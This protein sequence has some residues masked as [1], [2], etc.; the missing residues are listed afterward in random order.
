LFNLGAGNYTVT[1]VDSFG[2]VLNDVTIISQP[3]SLF[4]TIYSPLQFNGLH[5]SLAG[6]NDGSIDLTVNGGTNPYAYTWST[7]ASSEDLNN[8]TAGFYNVIVIDTNGCKATASIILTEPFVLELP[9]GFSP[10]GDGKNDLFVIH[11]IESYP[12]NTVTIYNRW[13]NVVYS[14]SG[15]SN[16]WNG[17]SNNGQALPD[18]T[19]FVILEINKGEIVKKNYVELRR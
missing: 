10:N 14:T 16:D 7:G 19:Y 5:I 4:L 18:A 6:S 3:D 11:G 15:Y 2:C 9:T 8:I 13:G 12:D 17:N 1:V